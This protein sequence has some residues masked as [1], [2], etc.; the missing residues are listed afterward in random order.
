MKRIAIIAHG[1]SNG[2]AER[3][4]AALANQFCMAGNDVLFIAVYSSEK[5]YE[6]KNMIKYIYI[7]VRQKNKLKKLIDRSKKIDKE[8]KKFKA[9]IAISFIINETIIT[10]ILSTVPLIYSLRTDPA[11]LL[12]NPF[13]KILCHYLYRKAKKIVFQTPGAR[14]YFN[15][16]I[17]MKSVIIPNPLVS[18]LPLWDEDGHDKVIVTACRLTKQKNLEMLI[19]AFAKF[20]QSHQ[21]YLLKIYGEGALLEELRQLCFKL[22]VADYVEFPGHSREIHQIISKSE[23]FVLTSDYEGLSNSMLE[24]LA[25]GIPTICTDCS[26][27]GAAMFIK[28]FENGMLIPVGDSKELRNRFCL[29]TDHP[30]I[31]HKLSQNSRKIRTELDEHVIFQ[32]WNN[33]IMK[34]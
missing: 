33:L 9:D 10:G 7:D 23:I 15:Q 18:N 4:A 16:E 20:H 5:E 13:H 19:R 26:P 32:R 22:N 11:R 27:G 31:E 25:I 12:S 2:G 30:E 3:V 1:L 28:D 14:D 6:L 21:D 24:A 29:L 17:Q 34:I 8:L